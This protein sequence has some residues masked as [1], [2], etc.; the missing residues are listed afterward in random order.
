MFCVCVSVWRVCVCTYV[1]VCVRACVC[2]FCERVC[3][4]MR[5]CVSCV[6]VSVRTSATRARVW[7]SGF[8][9]MYRWVGAHVRTPITTKH[10]KAYF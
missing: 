1:R 9:R 3:V 7:A 4:C 10:P 5:G 8:V 6:S 2:V